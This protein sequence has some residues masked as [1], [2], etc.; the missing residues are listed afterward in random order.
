MAS[1][2][3]VERV[4]ARPRRHPMPGAEWRALSPQPISHDVAAVAIEADDADTFADRVERIRTALAQVTWYLFNA[5]G[6]R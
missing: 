1:Y 2:V 3:V 6:W 4:S 5:E